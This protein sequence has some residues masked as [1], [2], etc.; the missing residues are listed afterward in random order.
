MEADPLELLTVA[1]TAIV[2][3]AGLGGLSFR[4]R[5]YAG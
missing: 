3:V 5:S 4:P 1:K 2:R